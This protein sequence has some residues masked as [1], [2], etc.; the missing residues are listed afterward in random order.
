MLNDSTTMHRNTNLETK[1]KIKQLLAENRMH[2]VE[3]LLSIT[4]GANE[5]EHQFEVETSWQTR[6]QKL[7]NI[8]KA[9]LYVFIGKI[10]TR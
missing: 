8:S 2:K 9:T 10:L 4:C 6:A 7:I 5:L 3:Q 1:I